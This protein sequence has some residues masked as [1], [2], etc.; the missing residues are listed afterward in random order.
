MHTSFSL[1]FVCTGN[2]CR[3]PFAELLLRARLTDPSPVRV[4]SAGSAAVVGAPMPA[5]MAALAESDA[6]SP[7]EHRGRQATPELLLQSDLILALDRR[8]RSAVVTSAPRTNRCTVTLREFARLAAAVTDDDL[9]RLALLE[10][11]TDRLRG[12]TRTVL[13]LRGSVPPPDFPE[14]DD[15]IDPFRL[16]EAEYQRSRD[17]MV[18]AIDILAR[19]IG[20]TLSRGGT[21]QNRTC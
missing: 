21:R 11:P 3:S 17:Q 15:V 10:S 2:I 20:A 9:E 12:L 5:E 19:L 13:S 6:L 4:A 14:D 7:S 8:N 16:S 1:L 18:P